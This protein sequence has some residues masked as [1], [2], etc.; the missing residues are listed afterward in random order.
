MS[1][2]SGCRKIESGYESE[3]EY[4]ANFSAPCNLPTFIRNLSLH[5]FES[6]N[7]FTALNS[8]ETSDNSSSILSQNLFR[9]APNATSTPK[10]LPRSNRDI[11]KEVTVITVNSNSMRSLEKRSQFESML[12]Q[13]KPSIILGQECKLNTEFAS[14][15]IF[16]SD[17]TVLRK[18]RSEGGGGVFILVRK[19]IVCSEETLSD[20][21][22]NCEIIWTQIKITG[23]KTL[24]IASVYRSPN[25]SI[26]YMEE[27]RE[28]MLKVY[29][30]YPKANF[31]IGGDMNLTCI[32]WENGERFKSLFCVCQ[33]L[34]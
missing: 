12:D 28:H 18:D 5:I 26:S 19:Y 31:L 10:K 8:I 2:T 34:G 20:F 32:D 1:L 24:N 14:S 13:H 23:S 4:V 27:L 6:A 3:Y 17:Y 33:H 16:P 22:T 9:P 7:S 29:E 25:S 30:K 11:S 15:E 21:K